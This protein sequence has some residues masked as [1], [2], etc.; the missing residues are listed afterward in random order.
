[1]V[2]NINSVKRALTVIRGSKCVMLQELDYKKWK[3]RSNFTKKCKNRIQ[4]SESLG[5]IT[6]NIM[7]SLSKAPN[8]EALSYFKTAEKNNKNPKKFQ[9][10]WTK[11]PYFLDEKPSKLRLFMKNQLPYLN[12]KMSHSTNFW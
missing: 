12:T 8:F 10:F 1:M 11:V 2:E 3:S 9:D 6:L 5:K 7:P 4:K